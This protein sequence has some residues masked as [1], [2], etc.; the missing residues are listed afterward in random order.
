MSADH[1]LSRWASHE[2]RGGW[3]LLKRYDS[4]TSWAA[5]P[6]CAYRGPNRRS[7]ATSWLLRHKRPW[8]GPI[9]PKRNT[10]S[11]LRR[12]GPQQLAYSSKCQLPGHGRGTHRIRSVT[13]SP[14][15]T[16][17]TSNPGPLAVFDCSHAAGS[18]DSQTGPG[19]LDQ[20]AI[21]GR[22]WRQAGQGRPLARPDLRFISKRAAH[23]STAEFSH[24]VEP[25]PLHTGGTLINDR[26]WHLALSPRPAHPH[27]QHA[28]GEQ[29]RELTLDPT[30][31]YQPTGAPRGPT[32]R[33]TAKDPEP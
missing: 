28:T 25:H 9:P 17:A 11:C 26:S 5:G 32:R 3:T 24:G 21:W 33:P 6:A 10:R 8:P 31:N 20:G 4:P 23:S 19:R 1:S 18:A 14:A 22:P 2:E 16:S 13:K 7:P 12:P 15:G 30:R 27:H 29:R